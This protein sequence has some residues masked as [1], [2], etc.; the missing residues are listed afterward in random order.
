VRACQVRHDWDDGREA[1]PTAPAVVGERLPDG[2]K[3]AERRRRRARRWRRQRRREQRP[4]GEEQRVRV[5]QS[6]HS[7]AARFGL[8][9]RTPHARDHGRQVRPAPQQLSDPSRR[10]DGVGRGACFLGP[11]EDAEVVE[12]LVDPR[13]DR[14][15]AHAHALVEGRQ[16]GARN[17]KAPRLGEQLKRRSNGRRL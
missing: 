16:R 10:I 12:Q 6:R 5:R 14:D 13:D 3:E 17:G 8:R 1:D 11:L 2:S 9:Q 7:V 4:L 15:G